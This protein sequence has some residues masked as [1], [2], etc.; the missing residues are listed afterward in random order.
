MKDLF[1]KFW[2]SHDKIDSYVK[3]VL[4]DSGKFIAILLVFLFVISTVIKILDFKDI[5]FPPY[6]LFKVVQYTL[7]AAIL[8]V[9]IKLFNNLPRWFKFALLV[10]VPILELVFFKLSLSIVLFV[11]IVLTSTFL[12]SIKNLN[13]GRLSI[14]Q[15]TMAIT[16]GCL[17]GLFVFFAIWLYTFE[18]FGNVQKQNAHL[19]E[20]K[21]VEQIQ[22]PPP[23]Q[24]G[25]YSIGHLTYGSGNDKHRMEYGKNIGLKTEPVNGKDFLGD[26]DG[27]SGWW[28]TKY[29]GFNTTQLPINGRVW[30]PKENGKFP[31]VLIVHGDNDMQ[32][33]SDAGYD[34]LGELLASRGIITVSVDQNFLNSSWSDLKTGPGGENDCRAWLLLKHLEVW[35]KW[36]QERSSPFFEKVDIENIGLI[37]HSRGGESVVHAALFNKLQYYPDNASVTF[38]FNYGIKAI[39]AI[40]PVDGQYRPSK[41]M[42]TIKDINYFVMHGSKDGQLSSYFGSRQYDRVSFSDSTNYF[43]SGLYI[44]NANHGQFNTTWSDDEAY[45]VFKGFL[46]SKNLLSR[47]EQQKIAKIYSSAFMEATLKNNKEY[48]PLFQD[49]RG[50]HEWLPK[51]VYMNQYEDSGL[52]K[53]CSYEE[54]LDV[55]SATLPKAVITSQKL[56]TWYE[57]KVDPSHT[58]KS[59]FIGWDNTRSK[60]SSSIQDYPRYTISLKNS[61]L[62]VDSL[63]VLTF[64]L[65][66]IVGIQNHKEENM[67]EH[68][69]AESDM[70]IDFTIELKDSKNQ[71][72]TF[73]LSDFSFLQNQI[74]III[75]KSDFLMG[76]KRSAKVFESFFFPIENLQP[77][78][79]HFDFSKL[80]ELNFVFNKS[81]NGMIALDNL[82]FATKKMN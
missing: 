82:G 12:F 47:E 57:S 34:Y 14:F 73:S 15:K 61:Q 65:A 77:Y 62:R 26:W 56:G 28:R 42:T 46:N 29:W 22:A 7:V 36:N 80:T 27:F 63:S 75:W 30:Y 38:D 45:T 39:M 67:G 11:F 59:V 24:P 60:P 17:T 21:G 79:Q 48:V 35:H 74:D 16:L 66:E 43:K 40:A 19:Q 78:N 23:D 25:E 50:G 70:N 64:S 37:G 54:D 33:F 2:I 1:S 71:S 68:S 51:T 20:A 32:D 44:Q 5:L 58:N 52:K 55:G 81:V 72:I 49:Y 4:N 76:K 41:T 9:L 18:G 10:A 13:F 53:I 8:I 69:R 3:R 31:L 6:S